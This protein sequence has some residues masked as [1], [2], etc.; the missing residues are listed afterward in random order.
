MPAGYT[1]GY[2]GKRFGNSSIEDRE[3]FEFVL[4]S[5][6]VSIIIWLSKG[7]ACSTPLQEFVSQYIN[8]RY[9]HWL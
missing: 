9:V 6:Q 5:Q 4:G 7:C 2:Q 3:P 1:K 8:L